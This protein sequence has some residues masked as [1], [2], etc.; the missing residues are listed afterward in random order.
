MNKRSIIITVVL[1]GCLT[2]VSNGLQLNP[3]LD[4][5]TPMSTMVIPDRDYL[6]TS[7]AHAWLDM[8]DGLQ[9]FETLLF[10]KFDTASLPQEEV[11]QA[12]LRLG[13]GAGGT[14]GETSRPVL[15]S[16]HPV[17]RD[18]SEMLAGTTSPRDFYVFN[19]HIL[20][21]VDSVMVFQDG[22]CYW[23]ITDIVN[24][25]ILYQNTAGSEG[26]ENL[27]LAITG[28][29][30]E[31]AM[32]PNDNEHTGFWSSRAQSMP[33]AARPALFIIESEDPLDLPWLPEWSV[34]SGFSTQFWILSGEAG[35]LEQGAA[36]DGYLENSFGQPYIEWEQ[37]E[38][39]AGSEIINPFLTWHPFADSPDGSA[40]PDWVGGVYGG[41]YRGAG[42]SYDQHTLSAF[43]PTGEEQG[44][45]T[46]LVQ[47]DWFDGGV[48]N[49]NAISGQEIS[50][51]NGFDVL[52]GT[53][54]DYN[55]YRSTR[56]YEFIGNPGE[57]EVE[58]IIWGQEPYLASF[59]VT[60]ALNT[61]VPQGPVRHINDY[62]LDGIINFRD[63]AVFAL[64]WMQT[65]PPLFYD[66]TNNDNVGIEDLS[67][68]AESWLHTSLF[69][70]L[71][72]DN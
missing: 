3:E 71:Q 38:E 64:E 68:F 29:D 1:C 57:I 24:N 6:L 13:S 46:V 50:L 58:F 48:V 33:N 19:D 55:W 37:E 26:Y 49:V 47:Y 42:G 67:L 53:A 27:G 54:G 25:W 7:N 60:T 23:D 20:D 16:V 40:H 43:V 45:L 66:L 12:W 30:D 9:S 72:Q 5:Y 17:D 56:A 11:S 44:S 32:D 61:A 65:E 14:M 22:V 15:V 69:R 18:I 70:Y 41:V 36:P 10:L 52:V 39:F 34:N 31:G 2:G 62:N 4:F 63:F 28:R 8:G 51:G 21:S 35:R 59:S